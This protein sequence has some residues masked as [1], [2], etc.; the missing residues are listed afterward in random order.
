MD[1][2]ALS[3]NEEEKILKALKAQSLKV[4]EVPVTG[5][6]AP[7]FSTPLTLQVNR[8]DP[9]ALPLCS[10]TN[11][12]VHFLRR[13]AHGQRCVVVPGSVQG[14]AGLHEGLVRRT[15]PP[16]PPVAARSIQTAGASPGRPGQ[17]LT[18]LS[19]ALTA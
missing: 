3:R 11:F 6:F 2:Y 5:Q 19:P 17:I 14:D 18:L 8:A 15:P 7:A 9:V 4:C 13:G 16:S 12:S 1:R 10:F